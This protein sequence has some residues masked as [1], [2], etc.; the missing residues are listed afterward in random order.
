MLSELS[1]GSTLAGYRIEAEVG[2]GGMGIV[3]RATQVTLERT[4]ALKLIAPEISRDERF[5]ERFQREAR[6]AASI[7]H[8]NV[9]PIYEAG[10]AGGVLFL[11]MRYVEGGD[12][13]ALLA[14][15]PLAPER[16]VALVAQVAE[17]LGAA[18]ARGLIHRDVKPSNVLLENREG[19]EQPYL[20]DFGLAKISASQSGLTKSGVFVGTLD[21]VSPEQIRGERLDARSDVYALGCLLHEA[22]TAQAPFPHEDEVAKL[23]AHM[24]EPPPAPSALVPGLPRELDSV[25]RRAMA[26]EPEGRFET[27]AELRDALAT[28]TSAVP[29]LHPLRRSKRISYAFVAA[30]VAVVL[31][32]AVA[33]VLS[34]R[35]GAE[36]APP[37]Q[38]VDVKPNSVAVID[39]K[40]N[41]VVAGI[42]LGNAPTRIAVAGGKV[43]VLYRDDQTISLIDASSKALEK[44]FGVG[45]PP[46]GLAASAQNVWVG[47]LGKRRPTDV[48]NASLAPGAVVEL[49]AASQHVNRTIDAP[50]LPAPP[51]RTV[52][53]GPLA[54]G[55]DAVWFLSGNQTVSRI[56][57]ASGTVVARMR[58]N[59]QPSGIAQPSIA[60]GE[61]GVWV[62][63]NDGASG[64]ALTRI[65]VRTN[66]LV[67][68]VA[69]PGAG[70]VA[71][72]LGGV[73]VAD[74]W[75]D[76]ES[77]WKIDTGSNRVVG[78]IRVGPLPFGIAVGA[79]AVWATSANGTVSRIDPASRTVIRK[80]PV[81][82]TPSGI[83]V[84]AGLV[85]V[86]IA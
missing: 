74:Q 17:A 77:V 79:G 29:S 56:D 61:Q 53:V 31:A 15:G 66:E 3:Y 62:S 36:E 23:W 85:W 21:Y 46:A 55:A 49:D 41:R 81:G 58:Y 86:A 51:A 40:T 78:S 84:G 59:G 57:R 34:T 24:H 6:I 83:A 8:P 38:A 70:A 64:G 25:V 37:P 73:W 72:G 14:Q 11:S 60:V 42:P 76:T 48:E 33:A 12:L 71:A 75:Y 52:D 67:A 47:T 39:P 10:E 2:R 30:L 27:M 68:T 13:G 82:G 35:G 16:A 19:R 20:A 5:R 45:A 50:P 28:A 32:A 80:I 26:K 4:V 44:T 65:D 7:D 1:A 22:L 63:V 54:L 43:W 9:L 18:H 69:V